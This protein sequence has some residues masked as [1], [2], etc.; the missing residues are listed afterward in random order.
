MSI[1]AFILSFQLRGLRFQNL[2]PKNFSASAFLIKLGEAYDQYPSTTSQVPILDVYRS[3]VLSLQK[4]KFW[5]DLREGTFI[6]LSIDQFRARLSRALE[7][8]AAGAV[9]AQDSTLGYF[10]R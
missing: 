9:S 3:Y 4:P 8:I 6:S 5:Q 2:I 1:P 10:R 7:E